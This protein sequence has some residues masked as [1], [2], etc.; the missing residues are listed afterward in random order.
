MREQHNWRRVSHDTGAITVEEAEFEANADHALTVQDLYELLG[1]LPEEARR[2][3]LVE[4]PERG[5]DSITG[6]LTRRGIEFH[7]LESG[8]R[9]E[10]NGDPYAKGVEE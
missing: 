1:G 4:C 9:L 5:Y 8:W 3:T 2:I 7:Q 6:Y 10:L